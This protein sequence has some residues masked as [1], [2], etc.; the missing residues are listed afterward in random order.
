MADRLSMS[1]DQIIDQTQEFNKIRYND[2][3]NTVVKSS[4][5]KERNVGKFVDN[6]K[7]HHFQKPHIVKD[8]PERPMKMITR[9]RP[10]VITPDTVNTLLTNQ[11]GKP[12]TQVA[13]VTFNSNVPVV[14]PT[15]VVG[16]VTTTA[17]SGLSSVFNRLG[18]TGTYVLFS[19]LKRTVE[20]ADIIELCR[21]VGE[22]KDVKLTVNFPGNNYARVLFAYE[23]DATACV[24]K[25]NGKSL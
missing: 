13:T 12:N 23:R 8:V 19:N 1:L 11:T 5:R 3:K 18:S 10:K 16:T 4:M 9:E 15:S 22:I 6:K 24:A 20:E 21:A 2:V 14:G 25:Y 7:F 17:K